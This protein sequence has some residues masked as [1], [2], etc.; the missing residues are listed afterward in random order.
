M[1]GI[2]EYF[3]VFEYILMTVTFIALVLIFLHIIY[4]KEEKK[5]T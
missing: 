5:T 2:S 3:T 1:A 4:G